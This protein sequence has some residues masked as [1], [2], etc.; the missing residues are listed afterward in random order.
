VKWLALPRTGVGVAARSKPP[1]DQGVLSA[2][3][4]TSL[5]MDKAVEMLARAMKD[6]SQLPEHTFVEAYS[7]PSLEE[8]TRKWKARSQR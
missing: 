7:Y 6:G 8:L 5:T 3:V 1:V 4:V 2:A